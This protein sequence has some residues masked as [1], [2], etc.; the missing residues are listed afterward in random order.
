M[1][2]KHRPA[3][4][5]GVIVVYLVVGVAAVGGAVA[6]EMRDTSA[7][8]GPDAD[9]ALVRGY[10]AAHVLVATRDIQPGDTF[11]AGDG[12]TATVPNNALVANAVIA[13]PSKPWMQANTKGMTAVQDIRKGEQISYSAFRPSSP[14]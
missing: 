1:A 13:F 5:I 11:S 3:L 9:P 14:P 7:H 2:E 4:T 10:G 8:C 12:C 6:W